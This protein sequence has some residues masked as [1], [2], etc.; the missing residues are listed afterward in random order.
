MVV[1]TCALES[2][3][4]ATFD[5]TSYGAIPNDATSDQAAIQTAINASQADDTIYFPAGTWTVTTFIEP[6]DGTHVIG[7]GRDLTTI[8]YR[9]FGTSTKVM[10]KM[11]NAGKRDNIELAGFTLDGLDGTYAAATAAIVGSYGTG[12]YIHDI[13]IRDLP[14][15]SSTAYLHGVYFS[16]EVTNS[17]IENSEF[18]NMGLNS[19]WGAAIR[20]SYASNQIKVIDNT[21][22]NTGR[23]GILFDNNSIDSVI[24]GNTVS[25]SG[26]APTA[27]GLGI[28]VWLGCDRALIEGNTIDHWL[29]VD[30]S[31]NVAVRNNIVS[32]LTGVVKYAGLEF[33]QGGQ[34]VVFADNIVNGG[35]H[36]GWSISGNGAS[37]VNALFLRN[38]I[39]RCQTWG[40]QLQGESNGASHIYV[41]D[42]TFELTDL[43]PPNN[44]EYPTGGHGFRV[45][46]NV[47]ALALVQCQFRQ[48][49]GRGIQW[50]GSDV[51]PINRFTLHD[52]TITDNIYHALTGGTVSTLVDLH[53][54][55][56]SASGNS[57]NT[58]PSSAG[59]TGNAEP[60]LTLQPTNPTIITANQPVIFNAAF[61][62]DHDATPTRILWDLGSGLP[63]N[64][65]TPTHTFQ[66]TGTYRVACVVWD[67]G[68]RPGY[69][70]ATVTVNTPHQSWRQFYF[71]SPNNS[72]NGA[73]TANPDS[74][75]LNNLGEYA[76]GLNPNVSDTAEVSVSGGI[77]VQR[78]TPAVSV[79][80]IPGGVDFRALFGRRKDFLAA[81]LTYTVQFSADLSMWVN[82]T[83][84]PTVTADDG[85]I[86]ACTVPYPFF[87]N[88]SK[89]R[90]FRVSVSV[91]P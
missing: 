45:N 52:C 16:R 60:V 50:G 47:T 91:T 20:C 74:D 23:G 88:G 71:G 19:I 65:L 81:G 36:V 15:S 24:F 21:I 87:I 69:A 37:K 77:V 41:R 85:E 22:M 30:R 75:A 40:V 27:P 56:T 17:R 4:A 76:F 10:V 49:D 9:Y 80:N 42:S 25:G 61:S 57:D 39:T 83:A 2:A 34:N 68:G 43:D 90:F 64:T 72:G 70:E 12:I 58:L 86:E 79:T 89:A 18:I 51:N 66:N 62:D 54:S 82:S 26:Q 29:S 7:A 31:S 1:G 32:D 59:F 55:G 63:A 48:N 84:T 73:D 67:S 35:A 5:I 44:Y 13:R 3:S 28:E 33:A 53:V 8:E 6:K 38:Q 14:A 11:Q 78:G 46:G